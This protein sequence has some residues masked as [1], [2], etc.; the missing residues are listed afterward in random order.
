MIGGTRARITSE[1]ARQSSLARDIARLQ[2]Q[3]STGKKN[4]GPSDDPA[5][6]L[7][8]GAIRRAQSDQATYAA[9]VE[10]AATLA[11]R[12]DGAMTSLSTTLDQARE[13]VTAGRSATYTPDERRIAAAQLRG[14]AQDVTALSAQ[15]DPRGAAIFP[16]GTPLAIPIGEGKQE[17]AT[18][19]KTALFGTDG[20]SLADILNAAAEALETSDDAA[21]DTAT[22]ASLDAIAAASSQVAE[23]HGEQGVRAARIDAQRDTL[24][25][26]SLTLADERSA[27]EGADV[28]ASIA[29][30]TTKLNTLEAAQAVFAKLNKQTLFDLIG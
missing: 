8:L 5:G 23:L 15:K 28:S 25:A 6:N 10:T 7:R 21:R 16:D 18:V 3:I 14:F 13:L 30:V 19:A 11:T 29:L 1:I 4:G 20:E 24:A 26:G 17:T 9:N 27:I 12:V 2:D 22:A